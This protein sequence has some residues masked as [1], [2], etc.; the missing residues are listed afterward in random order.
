[1]FSLSFGLMPLILN[2]QIYEIPRKFFG[3]FTSLVNIISH[4]KFKKLNFCANKKVEEKQLC[5]RLEPNKKISAST[6]FFVNNYRD[7]SM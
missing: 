5:L 3:F 2:F 7:F 4:Y 6:E 1:M